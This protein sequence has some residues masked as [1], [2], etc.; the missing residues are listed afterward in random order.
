MERE[1]IYGCQPLDVGGGADCKATAREKL[2]WGGEWLPDPQTDGSN[3]Q[4]RGAGLNCCPIRHGP[5]LSPGSSPKATCGPRCSSCL[6]LFKDAGGPGRGFL[7]G[8]HR[9]GT[10]SDEWRSSSSWILHGS[11]VLL[12]PLPFPGSGWAVQTVASSSYLLLSGRTGDPS[13]LCG[14]FMRFIIFLFSQLAVVRIPVI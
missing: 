6:C 8:G 7:S 1:Q 3:F 2:G 11:W 13:A 14:I 5:C 4:S 10:R 9:E 12:G